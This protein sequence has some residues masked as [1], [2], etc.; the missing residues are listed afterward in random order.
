[1]LGVPK[2]LIISTN[3]STAFSPGN[4]GSPKIISA[5]TVPEIEMRN[6]FNN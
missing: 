4:K 6:V 2:I 5:I 1:L 3:Y